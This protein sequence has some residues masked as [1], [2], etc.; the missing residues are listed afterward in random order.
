ML[1]A[2]EAKKISFED[3]AVQGKDLDALIELLYNNRDLFADILAE[4]PGPNVILHRSDTGSSPPI[5]KRSFRHSPSDEAEIARRVK[6]M[7]DAGLVEESDTPWSSPVLLVSKKDETIRFC[8]DYRGLNEVTT[9]TS[10]PLLTL[11]EVL[12]T[13]S[14]QRS[15]LWTSIDLRSGS[16]QMGPNPDTKD[17]TGFQTAEGNNV[18]NHVAMGLSGAVGVFSNFMSKVLRCFSPSTVV[19]YLDDVLSSPE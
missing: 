7:S 15:T 17:R 3:S 9:L 12:D 13:V 19:I 8:V 5:R 1:R 14:E 6:K 4:L 11:E 16:W 10:W 2:L 18:F